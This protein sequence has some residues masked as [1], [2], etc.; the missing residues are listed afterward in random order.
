METTVNIGGK[1]V[2]LNLSRVK[3]ISELETGDKVIVKHP[4]SGELCIAVVFFDVAGHLWVKEMARVPAP[5]QWI[6]GKKRAYN[7]VYKINK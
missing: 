2:T 6:I 5:Y 3:Y 1:R 7:E 4:E